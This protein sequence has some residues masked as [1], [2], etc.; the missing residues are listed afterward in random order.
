M[1]HTPFLKK[2]QKA[3]GM[4]YGKGTGE[5]GLNPELFKKENEYFGDI[6]IFLEDPEYTTD[7]DEEQETFKNQHHTFENLLL[8]IYNNNLVY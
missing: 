2:Y 5:I 1:K 7:D 3:N 4:F 6:Y 8:D